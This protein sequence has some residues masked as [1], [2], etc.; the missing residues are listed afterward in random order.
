MSGEFAARVEL[1][2]VPRVHAHA[3]SS[4]SPE[5][6]N[7]SRGG[8]LRQKLKPRQA[9][10][11]GTRSPNLVFSRAL[12]NEL[13]VALVFSTPS[14]G[15]AEGSGFPVGLDS[16]GSA[17]GVEDGSSA[18]RDEE[19]TVD[20]ANSGDG[21]DARD[22]DAD[23]DV[24]AASEKNEGGAEEAAGVPAGWMVKGQW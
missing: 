2:R 1:S 15:A 20:A 22:D 18:A 21:S 11:S 8:A 9:V 6:W 4:S 19:A 23:G 16:T 17:G 7:T 13:M 14:A 12:N 24:G 10:T 3:L 5:H